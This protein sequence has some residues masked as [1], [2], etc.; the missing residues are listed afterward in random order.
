MS[1]P[2]PRESALAPHHGAFYRQAL[3]ALHAAQV[4]F[5]VGGAHALA[6]YTGIDRDTKDF[7]IFVH[8]STC[9]RALEVLRA[10]GYPT[11]LTFPHWLGKAGP[12]AA[13]IHVFFSSGQGIAPADEARFT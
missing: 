3:L 5:L 9:D 7:D 6:H 11:E 4:P 8:S 10:A 2:V 13:A 1:V 12:G